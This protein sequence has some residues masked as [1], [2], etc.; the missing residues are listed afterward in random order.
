MSN[1]S[2]DY[3]ETFSERKIKSCIRASLTTV[4]SML[5]VNVIIPEL[6]NGSIFANVFVLCVYVLWGG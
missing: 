6:H 3:T 5:A 1:P 4:P 2:H